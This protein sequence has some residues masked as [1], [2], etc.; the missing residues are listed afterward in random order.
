MRRLPAGWSNGRCAATRLRCGSAWTGCCRAGAITPLSLSCRG[1]PQAMWSRPRARSWPPARPAPCR[2]ARRSASWAWS[3][4]TSEPSRSAG[5]G[6]RGAALVRSGKGRP[7]TAPTRGRAVV[8]TRPRTEAP[9]L[10]RLFLRGTRPGPRAEAREAGSPMRRRGLHARS[11]TR[12]A[13]PTAADAAAPLLI[14][15]FLRGRLTTKT[16]LLR[17]HP[18]SVV[19]RRSSGAHSAACTSP[20]SM[21]PPDCRRQSEA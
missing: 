17:C 1:L 14:P 5:C 21:N 3:K 18:C 7:P 2:R 4:L 8:R 13:R 16:T 19:R 20:T 10:I 12:E 9:L 6:R 11:I 15:L